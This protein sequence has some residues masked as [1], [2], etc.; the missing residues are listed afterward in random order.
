VSWT[1]IIVIVVSMCLFALFVAFK[2]IL[3]RRSLLFSEQVCK[4]TS[5]LHVL[6]DG[7]AD[8]IPKALDCVCSLFDTAKCPRNLH[9]HILVALQ[10]PLQQ[11]S[12]D[13]DMPGQCA[14][15]PTYNTFFESNVH[16]HKYNVKKREPLPAMIAHT[17]D[18]LHSIDQGAAVVWMPTLAK[19]KHHWDDAVRSEAPGATEILVYPLLPLNNDTTLVNLGITVSPKRVGFFTV[20]P[21]LVFAVKPMIKPERAQSLGASL[22][23]PFVAQK[24]MLQQLRHASEED[25]AF[26]LAIFSLGFTAHHGGKCIGETHLKSAPGREKNKRSLQSALEDVEPS[27]ALA[28]QEFIAVDTEGTVY[29]RSILG[30]TPQVSTEEKISK[31]GSEAKYETM[32]NAILF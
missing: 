25:L 16:L 1:T 30:M 23:H 14:S 26:S 24:S 17:L 18:E 32:K 21:S 12:W 15:M 5:P 13:V 3:T 4:S 19:V 11:T 22:R 2:A 31:W 29:A 6:V 8:D 10:T 28:W 7:G 27:R 20:D 9:V